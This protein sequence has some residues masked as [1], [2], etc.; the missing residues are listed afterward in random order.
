MPQ[1]DGP[2]SAAKYAAA[3]SGSLLYGVLGWVERLQRAQLAHLAAQAEARVRDSVPFDEIRRL[4]NDARAEGR[5]E[6]LR[7]SAREL[8]DHD[9]GGRRGAIAEIPQ[10]SVD[11]LARRVLGA[12]ADAVV[13]EPA[14]L[15]DRVIAELRTLAVSR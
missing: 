11:G 9:L 2:C 1:A 3:L 15:R 10:W 13:L 4:G 7:R 8:T 14:E 6:G 5:A 12:G